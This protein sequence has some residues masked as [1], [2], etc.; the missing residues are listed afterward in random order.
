MASALRVSALDAGLAASELQLFACLPG[1]PNACSGGWRVVEALKALSG[2][3][4]LEPRNCKPLDPSTMQNSAGEPRS[5]RV[6][7][8]KPACT[9]T[10]CDLA[11]ISSR[12]ECCDEQ[13]LAPRHFHNRLGFCIVLVMECNLF[14]SWQHQLRVRLQSRSEHASSS[15]LSPT[16][17]VCAVECKRRCPINL[18][19]GTFDYTRI[20][21]LRTIADVQEH[22]RYG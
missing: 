5:T 1:S 14:Q 10:C 18:P 15:S 7:F 16:T 13:L 21:P 20:K 11:S 6:L 4:E 3:N 17:L 8:C 2:L 9:R 22:I 19:S 12:M